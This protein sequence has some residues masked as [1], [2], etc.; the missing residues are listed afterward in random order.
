MVSK[1]TYLTIDDTRIL[2]HV[3]KAIE[4]IYSFLLFAGT[5]CLLGRIL[6][7]K[8]ADICTKNIEHYMKFKLAA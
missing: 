5:W 2:I 3:S 1:M 7:L 8:F 4:R 6:L